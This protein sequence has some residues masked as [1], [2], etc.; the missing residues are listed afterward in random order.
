MGGSQLV[1]E[2][3]RLGFKA[4]SLKA[5]G[6]SKLCDKFFSFD[7]APLNLAYALDGPCG[8]SRLLHWPE[9][10][11]ARALCALITQVL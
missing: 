9:E 6:S 2:G 10:V 11:S 8:P 1:P 3:S 4:A 7:K 5:Y